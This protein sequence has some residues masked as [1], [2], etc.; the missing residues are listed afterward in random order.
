MVSVNLGGGVLL[1]YPFYCKLTVQLLAKNPFLCHNWFI[2]GVGC[3]GG[4]GYY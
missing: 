2:K 4:V 3:R 1:L